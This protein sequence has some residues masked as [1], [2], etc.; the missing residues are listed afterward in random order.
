MRTGAWY[1]FLYLLGILDTMIYLIGILDT[2]IYLIGILDTM[3]YLLGCIVSFSRW[4][5]TRF[6]LEG[7]QSRS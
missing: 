1:G 5:E 6:L 7:V 2:M 3:I 4:R